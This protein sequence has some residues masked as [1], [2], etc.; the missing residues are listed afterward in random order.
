MGVVDLKKMLVLDL[1][2]T[3]LNSQ[4]Q[5]D[6][7]T[8]EAIN[9]AKKYV[10]EIVIAS[11][12]GHE[13]INNFYKDMGLE[14]FKIALNG[15]YVMDNQNEILYAN[16]IKGSV[17]E[18]ALNL[19]LK[20]K[21]KIFFTG[22]NEHIYFDQNAGDY[23]VS[24]IKEI[25]GQS[26]ERF[27]KFSMDVS[28]LTELNELRADLDKLSLNISLSD[29]GHFEVTNYGISKI[30]GINYLAEKMNIELSDIIAI[31]DSENDLAML[32]EVGT[33][34][35]MGN[36]TEEVKNISE[37]ITKTNNNFGVAYF[38]NKYFKEKK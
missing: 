4:K 38:L 24:E 1:D 13:S 16:F 6:K 35:A 5:I 2:G 36:A 18:A 28:R 17:L 37:Y 11:G 21:V 8:I 29:E 27:L 30:T 7:I 3:L 22:I 23:S 33:S 19:A 25:V 12:R 15:S 34:V 32:K 20:Y 9:K 10:N 14:G 26:K 31:G